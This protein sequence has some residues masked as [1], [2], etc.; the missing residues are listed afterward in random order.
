MTVPEYARSYPYDACYL[1]LAGNVE[2]PL[3]R[4]GG[5]YCLRVNLPASTGLTGSSS[6]A[7]VG[8]KRA[9]TAHRTWLA[10][11]LSA[12]GT[13]VSS[14]LGSNTARFPLALLGTFGIEVPVL[15]VLARFAFRARC[16]D[17]RRTILVGV[18]ASSLTLPLLWF[19]MHAA[20]DPRHTLILGEVAVA[21][22]EALLYKALLGVSI[23]QAVALSAVANALSLSAGWMLS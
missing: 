10:N 13:A 11:T 2:S 3:Y 15:L 12:L 16:G 14:L 8:V 5:Q 4:L 6:W 18:L 7:A 21:V 20:A 23:A 22:V 9:A 19:A 1:G 17:D